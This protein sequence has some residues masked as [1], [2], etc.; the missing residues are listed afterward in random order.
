MILFVFTLFLIGMVII[1]WKS[2]SKPELQPEPVS[3]EQAKAFIDTTECRMA[4]HEAGH[5]V[6][7]WACTY[8]TEMTVASIETKTGGVVEYV[9][10]S[11]EKPDGMWCA[12]V[13]TFAGVAA[14][15]FVHGKA[16]SMAAESDLLK[17]RA[18]AKK[19]VDRAV[20]PPWTPLEGSTPAFEKLY[21]NPLEAAEI[22]VLKHGYRM[23]RHSGQQFHRMVMMLLTKKTMRESDVENVLGGRTFTKFSGLFFRPAFVVPKH[24]R[25]AA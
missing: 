22:E 1:Y 14:E 6:A 24:P 21:K 20:P 2:M 5:A 16:S 11:T 23:A 25:K 17:A 7:A 10:H 8:V 15:A 13:I 18:L 3:T 9:I 19:L 12:L 4:V